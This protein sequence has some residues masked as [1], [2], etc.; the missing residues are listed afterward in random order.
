MVDIVIEL[1]QRLRQ[2]QI[3][4][5]PEEAQSLLDW[6]RQDGLEKLH[7]LLDS[8]LRS[9]KAPPSKFTETLRK[10]LPIAGLYHATSADAMIS[11]L[12]NGLMT[13]RELLEKG[14]EYSGFDLSSHPGGEEEEEEQSLPSFPGVYF[15]AL[16][17]QHLD[18]KLPKGF[19]GSEVA[20]IIDPYILN[21]LDYHVNNM[22]RRGFFSTTATY[23][24]PT[25]NKILP[26][27]ENGNYIIHEV[28]FHARVLPAFIKS[29]YVPGPPD[30]IKEILQAEGLD[31]FIPLVTNTIQTAPYYETD[32]KVLASSE[33][34]HLLDDNQHVPAFCTSDTSDIIRVARNCGFSATQIRDLVGE[35]G[36]PYSRTGALY[37]A[38]LQTPGIQQFYAVPQ[39]AVYFPPYAEAPLTK[40]DAVVLSQ[41]VS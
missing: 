25:L 4:D 39:P 22:D 13:W 37:Q 16:L 1:G 17:S 7:K 18:G 2:L 11:I 15:S 14:F 8:E 19:F 32:G 40:E 5:N 36:N 24:R 12:K 10:F 26:S 31:H 21:R 28:V 20:L 33:Y 35:G 29:I 41:L 38:I 3:A 30:E 9:G 27:V 34:R 23:S 6:V